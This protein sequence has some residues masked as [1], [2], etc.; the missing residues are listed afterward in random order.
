MSVETADETTDSVD[1][2]A[3]A[4]EL[5]SA[6][7]EIPAYQRF[8]DA[9][10][11]VEASEVAQEKIDEFESIRQEFMLARKTGEATQEDLQKVQTAQS[12]LHE[13]PVMAEY[14]E[15][16][17][18]LDARLEAVNDAISSELVVDFGQQAGGCCED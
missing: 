15:A 7:T 10:A 4:R 13:L 3:L 2:E 18:A 11:D 1:V 16:Q 17:Q 12:E 14:L 9:K 8:E 6:I 5:G